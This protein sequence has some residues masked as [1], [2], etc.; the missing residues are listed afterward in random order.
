MQVRGISNNKNSIFTYQLIFLEIS[1]LYQFYT[2]FSV[3]N[4]DILLKFQHCS[5]LNKLW[6]CNIQYY[7]LI[8]K[9]R[10]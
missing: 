1:L 2:N 5:S 6:I 4:K 8:M 9:V 10:N 3:T 7:C